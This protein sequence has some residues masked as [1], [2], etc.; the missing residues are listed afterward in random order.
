MQNLWLIELF[1][2]WAKL[3]PDLSKIEAFVGIFSEKHRCSESYTTRT[4]RDHR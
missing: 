3:Y 1:Q 4:T 2:F